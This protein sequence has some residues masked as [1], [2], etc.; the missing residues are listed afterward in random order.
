MTGAVKSPG[1]Y[2]VYPGVTLKDVLKKA[3]FLDKTDKKQLDLEKQLYS[4]R[5][6]DLVRDKNLH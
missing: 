6:A 2:Q 1:N 4:T 5:T 3:G